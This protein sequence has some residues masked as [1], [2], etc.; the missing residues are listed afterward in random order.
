MT[1][2][3]ALTRDRRDEQDV[4][5]AATEIDLASFDELS[6]RSVEHGDEHVIEFTEDCLREHVLRP[7]RRFPAEVALA[8]AGSLAVGLALSVDR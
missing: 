8:L 5:R 4:I 6:L 1:C 7:E 2:L 3:L